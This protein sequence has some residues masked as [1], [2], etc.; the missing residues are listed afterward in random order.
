MPVSDPNVTRFFMTMNEA[1]ELVLE[2]ITGDRELYI[3]EL[4]AYRLGDLALAMGAKQINVT[5]LGKYEKLHEGMSDGNTSDIARRMSVDELK[6]ALK[7][8]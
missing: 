2:A 1:V 8:V 3:P 5:G 6:Q 7:L 4:P